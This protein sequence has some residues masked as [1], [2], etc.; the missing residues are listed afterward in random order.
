MHGGGLGLPARRHPSAE[1]RTGERRGGG[2]RTGDPRCPGRTVAG[3]LAGPDGPRSGEGGG[4]R[5]HR[6]MSST[7]DPPPKPRRS[8]GIT[9]PS[10][11]GGSGRVLTDVIV[12]LG[13]VSRGV[14]DGAIERGT[15]AGS[16]AQRILVQDSTLSE[17]QLAPALAERF[18]LD[19]PDLQL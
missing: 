11:R 12:D 5:R 14:M 18:G 13:F 16:T 1:R 2:R 15:E 19:H 8:N 4:R 6:L 10:R 17:D 7:S 9:T 3:A